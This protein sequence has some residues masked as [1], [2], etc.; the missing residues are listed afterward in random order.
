[1]TEMK[2]WLYLIAKLLVGGALMFA[3]QYGFHLYPLPRKIRVPK[4]LFACDMAVYF[5][6]FGACGIVG[7]AVLAL[8]VWDQR[9]RCRTCLRKLIMPVSTGSW[10]RT[11]F[12]PPAH[13]TDLPLWAR[14]AHHRRS[15]NHRPATARLASARRRHLERVRILLSSP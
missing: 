7:V 14:H 12:G 3:L 2:Y 5:S 15:A 11:L 9:R 6:G 13:G 8:I 1:M 10:G 4:S